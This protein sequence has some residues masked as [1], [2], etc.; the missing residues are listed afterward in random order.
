MGAGMAFHDGNEGM[1]TTVGSTKVKGRATVQPLTLS[2]EVLLSVTSATGE[3]AG[4][5]LDIHS[6][7]VLG[8][9]L[10]KLAEDAEA[11]ALA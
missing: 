5:A 6:A 8:Q 7:M 4:A 11:K 3:I 10:V 9:A 1:K 2:H